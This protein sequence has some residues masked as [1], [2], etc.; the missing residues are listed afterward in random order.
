MNHMVGV[1]KLKSF[2]DLLNYISDPKQLV[3]ETASLKKN[4]IHN[5]THL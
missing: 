5:K 4:L 2:I 3:C 1:I